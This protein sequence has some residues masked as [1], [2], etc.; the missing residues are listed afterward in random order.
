M[1][2]FVSSDLPTNLGI[3]VWRVTEK[4]LIRTPFADISH[5]PN[6]WTK[7]CD[8]NIQSGFDKMARTQYVHLRRIFTLKCTSNFC[9]PRLDCTWRLIPPSLPLY[10]ARN[11]RKLFTW[12]APYYFCTR[13][14]MPNFVWSSS[15]HFVDSPLI[16][17]TT[18]IV[19]FWNIPLDR[20]QVA[21][22]RVV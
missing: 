11:R 1:S 10:L 14:G 4:A 17:C 6:F 13:K 8:V 2:R 7:K 19:H 21:F 16:G 3:W 12:S 15:R 22:G 20:P 9:D 5:S 18:M